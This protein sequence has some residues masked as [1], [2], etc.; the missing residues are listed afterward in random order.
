MKF[1]GQSRNGT[2]AMSP[3]QKESRCR[4]LA[5]FKVD[6]II[7]ETLKKHR[8][9]KSQRQLGAWWGLFCKTV[10]AEFNDR[11]WDTSY[12]FKLTK[13][14]GIGISKELLKEFMYAM[15]PSYNDPGE[16]T[17]MS[18]MNTLQMAGFFDDCRN[19][20]ASQWSIVVPEPDPKW[21][22]KIKLKDG[23]EGEQ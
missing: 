23:E 9:Q 8:N 2:L 1:Y 7:E 20:A 11:G 16:R 4:Y 22:E 10:L 14:T 6:D 18:G 15:C 21:R 3:E 12:I 19:F 13:P 5:N 17:T